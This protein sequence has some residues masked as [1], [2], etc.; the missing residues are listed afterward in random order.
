MKTHNLQCLAFAVGVALASASFAQIMPE[1]GYKAAREKIEADAHT[2]K[3][4]CASFS[5]NARDICVLEAKGKEKVARAELEASFKPSAKNRYKALVAK[6]E[7]DFAVARERCDDLSGNAKDVCRKEAKAAEISAKADAK[8]QMKTSDAKDLARD[9]SDT[10]RGEAKRKTSEARKDA[11]TDKRDAQYE[12]AKEKCD[13]YSGSAK[14]NCL[15]QAK[16]QFGK[17]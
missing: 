9:K 4:A 14:E 12:V 5:G 8:A 7:A 17:P 2:S 13:I 6:A 10:A 1:S 16:V 3:T 11:D 15:N